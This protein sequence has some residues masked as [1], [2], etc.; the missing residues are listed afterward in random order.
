MTEGV[1]GLIFICGMWFYGDVVKSE[2]RLSEA[3]MRY[4]Y[5]LMERRLECAAG[6]ME[7]GWMLY[8]GVD[9]EILGIDGEEF[10]GR[11]MGE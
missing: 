9:E 1:I 7:R 11:R 6:I 8:D 2:H 10:A 4:E 3:R 5:G